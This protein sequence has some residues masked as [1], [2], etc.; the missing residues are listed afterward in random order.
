M[1]PHDLVLAEEAPSRCSVNIIVVVDYVEMT[2]AESFALVRPV[3]GAEIVNVR[4]PRSAHARQGDTITIALDP[5]DVHL[6]DAAT[7]ER[8]VEWH[9]PSN[10]S[11]PVVAPGNHADEMINSAGAN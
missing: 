9:G 4:I 1:R 11:V 3:G 5:R 8:I 6:F 7:G 2:G 10:K